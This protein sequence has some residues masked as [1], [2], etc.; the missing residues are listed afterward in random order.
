LISLIANY[1]NNVLVEI[2]DEHDVRVI[3]IP[4]V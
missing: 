1:A 2:L 4:C 3:R